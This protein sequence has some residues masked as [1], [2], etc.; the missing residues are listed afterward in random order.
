MLD[1]KLLPFSYLYMQ[2]ESENIC[3]YTKC[4]LKEKIRE[5]EEGE[6]F[7]K[8]E[9]VLGEEK[10]VMRFF[11]YPTPVAFTLEQRPVF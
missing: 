2:S 4:K 7:L 1:D 10:N 8:I 3:T 6:E 11:R 9:V 5:F